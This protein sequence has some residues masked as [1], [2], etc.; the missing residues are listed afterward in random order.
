VIENKPAY[1]DWPDADQLFSK[2][3][4]SQNAHRV[5]GSGLGLYLVDQFTRM[6]GG[7][8]HYQPVHGKV[9][10]TLTLPESSLAAPVQ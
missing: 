5:T 9:R 7:T 2:Y 10:F 4:R 3:Y 6:L 1:D 8:V